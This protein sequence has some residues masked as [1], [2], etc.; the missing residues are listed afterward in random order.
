MNYLALNLVMAIVWMFLTGS[1]TV[2]GL[3]MGY[4]VAFVGL[5]FAQPI[6]GTGRYVR[7]VFGVFR[8]LLVFLRELVLANVQLARDILRLHPSF[9]PGFIRYDARALSPRET[10]LLANMVSLTPGTLTVDTDHG[11]AF[12]YVH[13]L[14]AEDP[15]RICQGIRLFADLIAAASGRPHRSYGGE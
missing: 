10:V 12:L 6:L 11:G 7:A 4:V 5:A 9:K 3:V 2:G 1:F 13:T 14:Y 8:L 15:E